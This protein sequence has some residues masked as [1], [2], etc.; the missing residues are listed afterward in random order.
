VEHTV[1]FDGGSVDEGGD[2]EEKEDGFGKHD[3]RD[4]FG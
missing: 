3:E 4:W 2:G 1:V